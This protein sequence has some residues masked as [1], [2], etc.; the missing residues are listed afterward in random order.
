MNRRNF[1]QSLPFLAP[2]VKAVALRV[3]VAT[4]PI[5]TERRLKS[6]FRGINFMLDPIPMRFD[7][8]G[9][10]VLPFRTVDGRCELNPAYEKAPYQREFF[11]CTS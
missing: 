1:L 11:V 3:A 5:E 4:A 6:S 8:N 7:E 2:A 9:A 10:H